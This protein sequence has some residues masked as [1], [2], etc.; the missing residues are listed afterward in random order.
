MCGRCDGEG[1]KIE[2]ALT[3]PG[4][5]GEVW[6]ALHDPDTL[7]RSIPACKGVERVDDGVFRAV[8]EAEFGGM[9]GSY[10]GEI[11]FREETPDSYSRVLISGDGPLGPVSGDG[12][13][14]LSPS[15]EGTMVK[16]RVEVKLGGGLGWLGGRMFEGVANK[17][18]VRFFEGVG[19]GL[20]SPPHL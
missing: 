9:K 11:R 7:A 5:P 20:P 2:G 17:M 14:W 8:F 16:Y 19:R 12:E 13:L 10:E 1:L 15:G 3:L 6:T 18:A 4:S